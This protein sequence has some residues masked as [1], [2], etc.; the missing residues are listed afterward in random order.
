MSA[1]IHGEAVAFYA[2][3]TWFS[4]IETTL[5]SHG[6]T[7]EEQILSSE[8]STPASRPESQLLLCCARTALDQAQ[9]ARARAL[10]SGELNWPDFLAAAL[11]H[12]VGP[13]VWKSLSAACPDVV[14]AEIRRTLQL[15]YHANALRN[16]AAVKELV[17][18][19]AILETRGVAAFAL[20]G[21]A[22][23]VQAYGDIALRQFSDLDLFVQSNDFAAAASMLAANGYRP[24]AAEQVEHHA[25]F[26][27]PHRVCPVE[28]HWAFVPSCW[29][30]NFDYPGIW[31][32]L[33]PLHVEGTTVRSPATDDL[34]LFL[35]VHAAKHCWR[36]L[37]WLCGVSEL[38]R[39]AEE[40][41]W[42][43]ALH[44]ARACGMQ[45][46]LDV[47]LRLARDLLDVPLPRQVQDRIEADGASAALAARCRDWLLGPATEPSAKDRYLF[48][49]SARERRQDRAAMVWRQV[50]DLNA[51][52]K[53]ARLRVPLLR[54]TYRAARLLRKYG[55]PWPLLK[56]LFIR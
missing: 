5:S 30:C 16:Q 18:L 1:T 23:A 55:D 3:P 38:V 37:E 27:H 8:H 48:F 53:G 11:R 21:P 46:L 6:K 39:R 4:A 25:T 24:D 49:L 13:L 47:G 45:R 12:G 40:L 29:H 22:L 34:L 36:R 7:A 52:D 54:H 32:R 51:R 44:Q 42:D 31:R 17:E 26:R 10:A 15:H 43:R 56:P 14:P 35:C 50:V 20:K 33:Q 28:L 9:Q 2:C 19:L 41:D